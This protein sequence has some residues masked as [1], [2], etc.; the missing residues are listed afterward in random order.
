MF[1]VQGLFRA[2]GLCRFRAEGWWFGLCRNRDVEVVWC[3]RLQGN[4][5]TNKHA[6]KTLN[7]K[8]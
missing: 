1:R 5:I 3:R 4:G 7:S 6:S 2:K 8:P